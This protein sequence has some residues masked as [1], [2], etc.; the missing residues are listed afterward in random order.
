MTGAGLH[1]LDAFINLA[2]RVA[3][4]DVRTFACKSPPDPRDSIAV[5]LQFASGATGTLATVRAGPMYWRV[6]AFGTNGWAEAD[7]EDRLCVAQMGKSPDAREL[8][9]VDSLFEAV[10]AFARAIA[11]GTV[12]PIAPEQML[13]TIGAF[14]AVIEAART[15]ARV[16]L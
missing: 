15:G 3:S 8:P 9:H 16:T 13:D 11:T 4:V 12:F 10:E 7:G 2:G 14:E 6:Q 5:L 1:V